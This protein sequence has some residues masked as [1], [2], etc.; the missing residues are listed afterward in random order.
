MSETTRFYVQKRLWTDRLDLGV[1]VVRREIGGEWKE[2]VVRK[3]L[4]PHTEGDEVSEPTFALAKTE[5]Q[6]LMD[7]LWSAG[8]RPS[9]GEGNTGQLG[10]TERHLEDMRRLVFERK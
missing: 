10:A 4:E 1:M 7:A 6:E 8:V 3:T 2:Y 9:S 5:A